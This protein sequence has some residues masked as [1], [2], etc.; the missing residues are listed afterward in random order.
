[1]D[2][3]Q[4]KTQLFGG[5]LIFG[6]THIHTWS[7]FQNKLYIEPDQLLRLICLRAGGFMKMKVDASAIETAHVLGN[8][9][10]RKEQ[11]HLGIFIK[12]I[13]YVKIL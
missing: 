8:S 9:D 3:L 6:N 4:W 10:V 7:T 13:Q 12:A 11:N 2:G 1:M 5:S